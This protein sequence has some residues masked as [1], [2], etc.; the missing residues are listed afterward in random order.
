[1]VKSLWSFINKAI[2]TVKV[3]HRTNYMY[4]KQTWKI[5]VNLADTYTLMENYQ[6]AVKY[7]EHALN[8][9]NNTHSMATF[10]SAKI[11]IKLADAQE[12]YGLKNEAIRNYE[13]GLDIIENIPN[14]SDSKLAEI[15]KKT[16]NQ[17]KKLR[18][19][20]SVN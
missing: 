8:V 20:Q 12:K 13:Q 19:P 16:K 7:L 11:Q 9:M 14:I 17:L 4:L 1:M 15:E 18:T 10:D 6:N 5:L 2:Q 3:V